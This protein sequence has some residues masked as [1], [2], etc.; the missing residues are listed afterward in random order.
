MTFHDRTDE[1]TLLEERWTEA[2][3]GRGQLFVVWGRRRV[4]KTELVAEFLRSKRGAVF[5]A[6]SGTESDQLA[7]LARVLGQFAPNSPLLGAQP[8]ASWD[9]A[10]AA[11]TE[12]C[13]SQPIALALDEYQYLAGANPNLGSIL[14]TWWGATGR[15]LPVMLILSGSAVSF[16]ERDV[17]GHTSPLYGRRTGQ[18]EVHPLGYRDAALFT[19]D[20][21]A[22]DRIRTYAICG[23]MPYYLEQFDPKRSV[24]DN[25]RSAVLSRS[26]VLR[27]EARL[28]LFEEL[29]DPRTYF[30]VLRS[31][32]GGDT[33]VSEISNRTGLKV[34]DVTKHL[35]AL[36]GLK[37]VRRLVP[38]GTTLRAR[39]RLTSYEL[40]DPYLRFWFRFVAPYEERLIGSEL[41]DRHMC[42]TVA[43]RLDEFVAKPAF[44]EVCRSFML[45]ATDAVEVGP[46]W[47]QV[48]TGVERR[49]EQR[50]V[51]CVALDPL[52]RVLALGTCKWT[53][54]PM[55]ASEETLLSRLHIRI[56]DG[57]AKRVPH[58]FFSRS[59][60][61]PELV[62]LAKTD[63]GLYL[64]I[65]LEELFDEIVRL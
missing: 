63:P 9:V 38:A 37:L 65:G 61:A 6:T 19:P 11:I 16:F 48:P 43:P 22:A 54:D 56:A 60:F 25:I 41:I 15:H 27:E 14:A 24:L 53:N 31:L 55:P 44:E 49:T 3:A 20:Y 2:A 28:L 59:G 13:R 47:G 52:R 32:A 50:E 46:W 62:A 21:E 4:G 35:D 57:A 8:F 5:E 23:G 17:M 29:P 33:R 45:L 42:E 30:S 34:P 26:G 12:L 40:A 51:D 1:L 7:D 64:L 10:L 18:L 39:T 58:F 36:Q